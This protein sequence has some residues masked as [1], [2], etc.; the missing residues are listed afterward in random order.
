MLIYKIL[1]KEKKEIED[2]QVKVKKK[3]KKENI[4]EHIKEEDYNL[5]IINEELK[6]LKQKKIEKIKQ[7]KKIEVETEKE[8]NIFCN[9]KEINQYLL[10]I[11][12][13]IINCDMDSENVRIFNIEEISDNIK[14]NNEIIKKNDWSWHCVKCFT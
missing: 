13:Y 7:L 8:D 2:M 14:F 1:I 3:M 5:E 11:D 10:L 12:K 6:K 9:I 4:K